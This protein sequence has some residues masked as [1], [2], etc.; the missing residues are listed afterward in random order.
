MRSARLLQQDGGD[1][2]QRI[3]TRE[4]PVHNPLDRLRQWQARRR[5][6]PRANRPRASTTA[7]FAAIATVGIVGAA[8]LLE[9][10]RGGG[11]EGDL[12]AYARA[13]ALD[14]LDFIQVAGRARRLLFLAEISTAAAPKR[15]AAD[16]IER[17]ARTSGLDLVVLDVD[18]NEQPFI[19]LYLA[20]SPEDASIL[21]ARPRATRES[22]GAS[23]LYLDIYRTV[24]R[25]NQELGAD[26]RIRIL[27]ADYPGWP[28]GHAT[29]PSTAAEMFG[30]RDN[31]MLEVI[32]TRALS[33]SPNVR[34]LFFMDGLHT[35]KSGGARAQTGGARPVEVEWLAAQLAQRYPQ[36]VYTILLDAVPAG[37][38]E[39]EVAAY[40][41]TDV[42]DVFR[43]AGVSSGTALRID[44]R[45]DALSRT[46]IRVVGTTGM[47]F[48]LQPRATPLSQ[49]ADA[50]IY[51]GS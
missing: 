9:L 31:H 37:A 28:P 50:Y 47:D 16:A 12:V 49:L 1:E 24:W 20:T 38:I 15:F 17:L 27:A 18:A 2:P 3:C 51:F 14:P 6:M 44:E 5:Y 13:D 33:R 29:A 10:R 41:G 48:N 43:R 25:I 39:A 22:A 42:G 30:Q 7:N 26:R 32:T 19:D 23:R 45:F 40:R 21:I 36:D 4:V 35:L 34:M 8:A 46:P 11:A